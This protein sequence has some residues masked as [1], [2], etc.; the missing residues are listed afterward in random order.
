MLRC[1]FS[2]IEIIIIIVCSF[3]RQ[4]PKELDFS[5]IRKKKVAIGINC[6]PNNSQELDLSTKRPLWVKSQ[7]RK[8]IF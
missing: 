4:F 1:C 6:K 7:H 3:P 2:G 5:Y 8:P